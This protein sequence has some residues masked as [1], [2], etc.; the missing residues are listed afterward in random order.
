MF[1]WIENIKNTLVAK[2]LGSLIRT[3]VAALA[4]VIGTLGIVD[5]EVLAAW[6]EPTTAI[7]IAVISYLLTQLWSLKIKK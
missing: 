1:T 7:L 4:G 6:V 2:Y 3:G 5:P